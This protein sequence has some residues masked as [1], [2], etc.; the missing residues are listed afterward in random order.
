MTQSHLAQ[1]PEISRYSNASLLLWREAKLGVVVQY[2]RVN[3]ISLDDE[4]MLDLEWIAASVA[5][6]LAKMEPPNK[7]KRPRP[8]LIT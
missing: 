7:C 1:A 8:R 6:H 3:G 5:P 2:G 4:A